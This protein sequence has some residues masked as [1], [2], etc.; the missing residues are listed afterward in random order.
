[1]NLAYFTDLRR[2]G[3]TS[4]LCLVAILGRGMPNFGDEAS[5]R[6]RFEAG[7]AQFLTTKRLLVANLGRG[8]LFFGD[9][10]ESRHQ[11]EEKKANF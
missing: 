1:M 4:P 8:M 3:L 5:S 2:R 11:F 9:E 6:H 7:N 10:T